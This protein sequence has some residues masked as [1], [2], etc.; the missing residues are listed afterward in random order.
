MRILT[1]LCLELKLFNQ[2]NFPNISDDDLRKDLDD[3]ERVILNDFE[4]DLQFIKEFDR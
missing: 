4:I 3:C 2:S 1:C